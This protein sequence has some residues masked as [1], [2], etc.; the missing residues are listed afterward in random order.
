M[1]GGGWVGGDARFSVESQTAANV[2]IAN[3]LCGD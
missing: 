1:A 2:E 3:A